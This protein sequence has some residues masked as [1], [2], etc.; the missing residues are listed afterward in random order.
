[1]APSPVGRAS[2]SVVFETIVTQ[3]GADN[4]VIL[5]RG[6]HRRLARSSTGV[7]VPLGLPLPRRRERS[8][9]TA[10]PAP[11]CQRALRMTGFNL[12]GVPVR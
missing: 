4:R 1:M 6:Q 12:F 9:R 3:S 8:T 11:M 2:K 5:P 7:G 10:R